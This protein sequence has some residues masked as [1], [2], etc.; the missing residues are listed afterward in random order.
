MKKTQLTTLLAILLVLLLVMPGAALADAPAPN[1][2]YQTS[3]RIRNTD[4]YEATCEVRLYSAGG[5]LIHTT[6]EYIIE[7][8]EGVLVDAVDL[9]GIDDGIYSAV[10]YCDRDV[11]TMVHTMNDESGA[12]HI[13]TKTPATNLYA[14][15]V[16]DNYYAFYTTIVVQNATSSA[17]N[18]TVYYFAPGNS[19][20]VDWETKSI[21]ANASVTYYQAGRANLANNVSYSARIAG[22]GNVA[23]VVNIYGT[24]SAAKQLYAYT[25]FTSGTNKVYAPVVMKAYYGLNTA[26][27]VMNLGSLATNVTVTYG[28][29]GSEVKYVAAGASQVWYTPSSALP[30]G[31]LTSAVITSADPNGKLVALVNESNSY[32]RAATYAAF[33]TG[34]LKVVSPIVVR[35]YFGYNSSVTCQNVGTSSTYMT[36]DYETEGQ[37]AY[38]P[39]VAPGGSW[40]FYQPDAG[41]YNQGLYDGYSGS[42][43]VTAT[44]PIVCVTNLDLNEAPDVTQVMD[45]LV[46]YEGVAE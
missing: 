13:G 29:G 4:V 7:P 6:Q 17:Q 27:T 16:Y 32:N 3:I 40:M 14:P 12:A 18:V 26:I 41:T 39:W 20:A 45:A 22:A 42:A 19:V 2:P 35:R 11:A 15:A 37:P 46:S 1:G 43:V 5:S 33:A 9:Y 28:A 25:P 21:P 24:G 23:A 10:V 38:S 30:N 36:I 44:S 8:G 34:S 31:T